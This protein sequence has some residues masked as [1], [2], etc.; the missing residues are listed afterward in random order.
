[1]VVPE[2]PAELLVEVARRMQSAQQL[3]TMESVCRGWRRDLVFTS[4]VDIFNEEQL[5]EK[6]LISG[7]MS[8]LPLN[9]YFDRLEI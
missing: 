8:C 3:T 2:L 7:L 9:V 6:Q 4:F 1:M 5:N